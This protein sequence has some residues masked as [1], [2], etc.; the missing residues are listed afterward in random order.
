MV[1]SSRC[2]CHFFAFIFNCKVCNQS[3]CRKERVW[4]K[5][6]HFA[7]FVLGCIRYISHTRINAA[8]HRRRA[9]RP[10]HS[11]NTPNRS[12]LTWSLCTTLTS[13]HVAA[14]PSSTAR[15]VLP[16]SYRLPHSANQRSNASSFQ[17]MNDKG[18]TTV[19][20]SISRPVGCHET[21]QQRCVRVMDGAVMQ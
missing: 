18:S 21:S 16:V 13:H 5:L 7:S 2:L 12:P 15:L 11:P 4:H 1:P 8:R 9:V 14:M 20:C 19:G 10:S 17:T 6:I 3:I